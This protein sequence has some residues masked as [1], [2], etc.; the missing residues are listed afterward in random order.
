MAQDHSHAPRHGSTDNVGTAFFLNL[1][2]TIIEIV[3]GVF[4]NSFAILADAIHDL[5]DT[6]SLGLAWYFQR[7]SRRGRSPQFT[8]GYK[9][10]N[11][12][13]AVI[14]GMVLVG[15]SV[16]ILTEAIPK[17]WQPNEVDAGGMI[18]LAVLGVLV[19]GAAVFR[20]RKGGDSLNEQVLTWHLL[21]DVLG[22][23]AVLIGSVTMY[24]YDL[25]WIDPALSIAIAAFV[26]Y[27]VVRRLWKAGKI[28]LQGTP[29]G[30]NYREILSA[31]KTLGNVE[32][33]HHLHLWTLDGEYYLGSVHLVLP[34][35][36]SL[37]TAERGKRSVRELVRDRFGVQ[38]FTIEVET[39]EGRDWEGEKY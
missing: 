20:L 4:T 9:R 8:F 22:W 2:F 12:L 1:G 28:I 25:P 6:L 35:N 33:A 10:F 7:L 18:W 14:T 21:E 11:T 37:A 17:L 38:H 24:F 30:L 34:A 31:I 13:G 23:I 27:N 39:S 19:N 15:G 36:V 29:E 3:G 26:L 5:G 32:D 16:F